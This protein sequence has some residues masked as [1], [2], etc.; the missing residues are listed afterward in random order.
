MTKHLFQNETNCSLSPTRTLRDEDSPPLLLLP[1]AAAAA[2]ALDPRCCSLSLFHFVASTVPK[3]AAKVCA[4]IVEECPATTTITTAETEVVKG[5]A[6]AAGIAIAAGSV[7]GT[8]TGTGE[9]EIGTGTEG[10]L[11]YAAFRVSFYFAPS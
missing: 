6:L 11:Q 10:D 8:E 5:G 9:T 1:A 7:I 3:K 4:V 2:E